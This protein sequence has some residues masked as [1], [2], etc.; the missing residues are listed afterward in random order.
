MNWAHGRQAAD[1]DSPE[2]VPDRETSVKGF[3]EELSL[4]EQRDLTKFFADAR[5]GKGSDREDA[6][7]DII[8]RILHD[9][10][11]GRIDSRAEL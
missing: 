11:A 3:A 5:R 7:R 1:E 2:K 10:S 6:C 9:L 4:A 8:K